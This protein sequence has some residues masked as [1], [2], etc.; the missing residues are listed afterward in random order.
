[1]VLLFVMFLVRRCVID[2]LVG[3]LVR[4]LV[5]LDRVR[6]VLSYLMDQFLLFLFIRMLLCPLLSKLFIRSFFIWFVL[7][8]FSFASFI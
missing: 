5:V 6:L 8:W 3:M 1:M 4:I 2:W 7:S